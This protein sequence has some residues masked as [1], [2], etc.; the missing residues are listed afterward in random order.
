MAFQ[1]VPAL[2]INAFV[3]GSN[4]MQGVES[5]GRTR[6]INRGHWQLDELNT[7]LGTEG[8]EQSIIFFDPNVLTASCLLQQK[9]AAFTPTTL[10]PLI[11]FMKT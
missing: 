9:L 7:T 6:S 5:T 4:D 1:G 2:Y 3:G 11:L 8:N 10:T